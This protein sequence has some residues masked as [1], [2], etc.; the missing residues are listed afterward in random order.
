MSEKVGHLF[1]PISVRIRREADFLPAN[2]SG[3]LKV[4]DFPILGRPGSK[5]AGLFFCPNLVKPQYLGDLFEPILSRFQITADLLW[6]IFVKV[7]LRALN[8]GPLQA[9][10][11]NDRPHFQTP[12][13][14]AQFI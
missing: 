8:S 5:K 10:R 14:S 6:L 13:S 2:R 9:G 1:C 11:P 12:G 4:V 3:P 7:Q